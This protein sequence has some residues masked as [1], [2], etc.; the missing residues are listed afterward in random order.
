MSAKKPIIDLVRGKM[1]LSFDCNFIKL[2]GIGDGHKIL[3]KFKFG[4]Y[5]RICLKLLALVLK[6]PIFDPHQGKAPLVLI[7]AVSGLQDSKTG[8][9]SQ[10]SSNFS[11]IV[12]FSLELLVLECNRMTK[13]KR[14]LSTFTL[15]FWI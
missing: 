2:A 1:A 12:Q 4:P 7:A 5:C 3:D 13:L 10:T 11:H 6:K 14:I 15:C 8:M 9:N